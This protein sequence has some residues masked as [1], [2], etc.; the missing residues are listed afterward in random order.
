MLSFNPKLARGQKALKEVD[1]RLMPHQIVG[2]KWLLEQETSAIKGGILADDMGLGKTIQMIT[3]MLSNPKKLNLVVVPANIIL[4]WQNDVKKFAP[5]INLV[6]HWGSMRINATTLKNID[7]SEQT[8]VITSYGL[9]CTKSINDLKVNRLICDEAHI[10]RNHRTKVFR[11]IS[12]ID[13]K[14]RWAMTGTPIQ[15]IL[16]DIINLFKFVGVHS[17]SKCNIGTLI[18]TGLLR[19]T[20]DT[21]PLELPNIERKITMI[22]NRSKTDCKVYEKIYEGV[23]TDPDCQLERLLR[24]RQASIST[25]MVIKS[26]E[27]SLGIDLSRYYTK[28]TKLDYILRDIQTNLE[29]EERKFIVFTHFKYEIEYMS[30]KLRENGIRFGGISGSVSMFDRNKII[31]DDDNKVLLVQIVSGGTGLNLQNYNYVYFTSPHWNPSMEDQAL[32]RVYRIGQKNKVTI[33]H[34]ICKDTIESRIQEIQSDK[35]NLISQYI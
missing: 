7:L 8:I 18:E 26:L 2:V 25:I 31:K 11:D 21:L 6:V 15:N 1:A 10:F 19:R 32:C 3:L 14:I 5:S 30:K 16:K 9:V 13:S 24:L 27:K 22:K 28:N 29:D 4:Q 34:V 23:F 12:K 20:K 17:A 33:K 35:T